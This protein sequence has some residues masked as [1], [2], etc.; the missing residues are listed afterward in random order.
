MHE[1][2]RGAKRVE[3]KKSVLQFVVT[4]NLILPTLEANSIT[5]FFFFFFFIFIFFIFV[6]FVRSIHVRLVLLLRY[7]LK[8]SH[9]PNQ[10]T[11]SAA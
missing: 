9:V 2:I 6:R 1:K 5:F 8:S 3:R 7:P 10:G 4:D 11:E